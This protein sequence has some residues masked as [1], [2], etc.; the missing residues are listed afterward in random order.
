MGLETGGGRP[1]ALKIAAHAAPV[2]S[3]RPPRPRVRGRGAREGPD[4]ARRAIAAVVALAAHPE[5]PARALSSERL[6]DYRDG[7]A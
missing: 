6:D 3:R 5:L 1:F 2:R 7:E 4:R